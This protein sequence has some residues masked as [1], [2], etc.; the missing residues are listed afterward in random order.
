MSRIQSTDVRRPLRCAGVFLCEQFSV[1]EQRLTFE[2]PFVSAPSGPIKPYGVVAALYGEVGEYDMS[3]EVR[4]RNGE[5]F[6]TRGEPHRHPDRRTLSF[7]Y[8]NYSRAVAGPAPEEIE[9][10]VVCEGQIIGSTI[11][12]II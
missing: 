12:T 3:I 1:D 9:H 11:L 5:R 8:A 2:R 6:I 10:V 7:F 4:L